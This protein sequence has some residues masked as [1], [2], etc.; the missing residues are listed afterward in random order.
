MIICSC[1]VMTRLQI[2]QVITELLDEDAWRLISPGMV[3]RRMQ[4]RGRCCG[5]FPNL[6]SLIVATTRNYH[7]DKKTP[8]SKILPFI[9]K[10]EAEYECCEKTRKRAQMRRRATS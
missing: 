8:E 1:N 3:Y 5:C 10:I 9:Q 6:I 7:L 2:E 4:K